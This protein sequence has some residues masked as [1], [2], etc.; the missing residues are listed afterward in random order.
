[1]MRI[2]Q[3]CGEFIERLAEEIQQDCWHPEVGLWDEDCAYDFMRQRYNFLQASEFSFAWALLK[4][5]MTNG[6]AA[7]PVGSASGV[8]GF[9]SQESEAGDA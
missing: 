3:V 4:A 7:Q 8:I 9:S 5:N 2:Q 6:S 1:M